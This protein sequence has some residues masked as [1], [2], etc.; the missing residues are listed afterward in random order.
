MG[1]AHGTDTGEG[2]MATRQRDDESGNRKGDS[3]KDGPS[4]QATL[5]EAGQVA[6][7]G[8]D[9]GFGGARGG[10]TGTSDGGTGTLPGGAAEGREGPSA[11]GAG[12]AESATR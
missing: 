7:Q 5:G 9:Q 12:S 3:G 1:P 6:G 2:T 8:R 4:G 10:G 11:T